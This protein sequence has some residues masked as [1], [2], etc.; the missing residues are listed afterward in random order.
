M[1]CRVLPVA[2]LA[3]AFAGCY[4]TETPTFYRGGPRGRPGLVREETPIYVEVN[5]QWR[6]PG[7]PLLGEPHVIG[8]TDVTIVLLLPVYIGGTLYTAPPAYANE[9]Y[10]RLIREELEHAGFRVVQHPDE[11]QDRLIVNLVHARYHWMFLWDI[12]FPIWQEFPGGVVLASELR[13]ET[14]KAV[15]NKNLMVTQTDDSLDMS[16]RFAECWRSHA[17]RVAEAVATQHR[18]DVMQ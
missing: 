2:L 11:A 1:P 17:V 8:S 18:Y 16:E 10:G 13:Y 14:R 15:Y 3:A 6:E 12:F 4:S 7:A 9:Q 5:A